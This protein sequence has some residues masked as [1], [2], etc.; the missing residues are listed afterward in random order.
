MVTSE[1]ET[2]EASTSPSFLKASM[3]ASR[4]LLGTL[5]VRFALKES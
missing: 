2:E 3:E 1:A 5:I 4:F